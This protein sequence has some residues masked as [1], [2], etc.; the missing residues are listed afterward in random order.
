MAMSAKL[1]T[2]GGARG[3]QRPDHLFNDPLAADLAGPDGFWLMDEWRL[4]GM[5]DEERI[6][7]GYR[8]IEGSIA[9]PLHFRSYA[10]AFSQ[11]RPMAWI[12]SGVGWSGRA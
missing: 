9:R 6:A 11:A 7:V 5:S 4:P 1:T 12:S 10:A 2:V 8:S 3:S